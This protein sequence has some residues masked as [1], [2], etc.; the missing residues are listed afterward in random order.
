LL[1]VVDFDVVVDL[2]G[3][4]DVD[5]DVP[6]R[7]LNQAPALELEW[8]RLCFGRMAPCPEQAS[9]CSE[10]TDRPL[11]AKAHRSEPSVPVLDERVGRPPR[12]ARFRPE[13]D[14]RSWGNNLRPP[15]KARRLS[16]EDRRL[17][18]KVRCLWEMDLRLLA[19]ARCSVIDVVRRR[20]TS[21]RQER[22]ARRPRTKVAY[23]KRWVP[24]QVRTTLLQDRM[25]R[26]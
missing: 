23:E 20:S 25:G 16:E 9:L 10:Q 15:T 18:Q 19:G 6:P 8:A 2:D 12:K 21:L 4:G 3:N 13:D 11:E 22:K 14:R 24:R 26:F 7:R 1:V 17:L 5:G